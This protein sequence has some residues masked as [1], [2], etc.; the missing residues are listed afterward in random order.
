[1]SP[2]LAYI[3]IL[4]EN[5]S[6]HLLFTVTRNLALSTRSRTVASGGA[7]SCHPP[8]ANGSWSVTA[9]ATRGDKF[10]NPAIS[11]Y[12]RIVYMYTLPLRNAPILSLHITRGIDHRL[13]CLSVC[14]GHPLVILISA[15]WASLSF[16]LPHE[17]AFL[18]VY[19]ERKTEDRFYHFAVWVGRI[20]CLAVNF[21]F[22]ISHV[23]EGN[24]FRWI[25][26]FLE[27]LLTFRLGVNVVCRNERL[28]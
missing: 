13:S 26:E 21:I 14:S 6:I 19:I 23:R 18:Y 1:M 12:V 3:Y 24:F 15:P 25:I 16:P 17:R 20:D 22:R 2:S 10:P 8:E 28:S 11:F 4:N 7:E 9:Q 5:P 27:A